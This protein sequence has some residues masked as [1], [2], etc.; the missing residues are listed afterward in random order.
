MHCYEVA[1][2]K[3]RKSIAN[4]SQGGWYESVKKHSQRKRLPIML[5]SQKIIARSLYFG[6]D[7]FMRSED[8][9]ERILK[10][11]PIF[12]W[13][14]N[15]ELS[16]DEVA[17]PYEAGIEFY[18]AKSCQ[19]LEFFLREENIEE[20]IVV[21]SYRKAEEAYNY[22]YQNSTMI[23]KMYIYCRRNDERE[24]LSEKYKPMKILGLI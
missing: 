16:E 15:Q 23:K 18:F 2:N 4:I 17:Y 5:P 10:K 14:A 24:A 6:G 9:M 20:V 21:A 13:V 19:E 22:F 11:Y 1:E 8:Y 3:F 7:Q 12:I